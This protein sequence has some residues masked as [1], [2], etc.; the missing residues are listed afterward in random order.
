MSGTRR[1]RSPELPGWV[2]ALRERRRH[3]P[4][5]SGGCSGQRPPQIPPLT[6]GSRPRWLP[7]EVGTRGCRDHAWLGVGGAQHLPVSSGLQGPRRSRDPHPELGGSRPGE[8]PCVFSP[9]G[10]GEEA[11][12]TFSGRGSCLLLFTPAPPGLQAPV[13]R[14]LRRSAGV[15]A[16]PRGPSVTHIARPSHSGLSGRACWV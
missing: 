14:A 13:A 16:P 5:T 1:C 3:L 4:R 12:P 7:Q 2:P 9:L 10:C 15:Q 6:G 11:F 8:T